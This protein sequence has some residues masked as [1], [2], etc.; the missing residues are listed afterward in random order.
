MGSW[1]DLPSQS[2]SRFGLCWGVGSANMKDLSE[3]LAHHAKDADY[4]A[5]RFVDSALGKV[6]ACAGA[7][8]S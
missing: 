5:D 6:L 8:I 3:L 4:L 7:A 2:E 1:R